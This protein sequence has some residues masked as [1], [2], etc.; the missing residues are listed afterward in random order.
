MM[1]LNSCFSNE[2]IETVRIF[3]FSHIIKQIQYIVN[4][5]N[6]LFKNENILN[7]K[8][9]ADIKECN[10]CEN[11]RNT[12]GLKDKAIENKQKYIDKIGAALR[13]LE[14]RKDP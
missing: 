4:L 8:L 5:T 2:L 14:K 12:E 13:K 11:Y 10:Q 3:Q 1:V 9:S 7:N 6:V